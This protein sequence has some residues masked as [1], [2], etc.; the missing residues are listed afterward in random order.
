[1]RRAAWPEICNQLADSIGALTREELRDR[2]TQES[3][4]FSF[5]ASPPEV[6]TDPAVT[7]NGY[8]M[9]HP[10]HPSL[11]LAA[12]PAQFDNELP[13]IRRAGPD[14]GEH[15]REVL[16]EIGYSAEEVEALIASAA[17]LAGA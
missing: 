9:A 2:L 11:R 1:V 3:C 17:V 15:T 6:V 7:E 8:L 13:K 5:V 14:K 12:A 16:A 4:I 10:T